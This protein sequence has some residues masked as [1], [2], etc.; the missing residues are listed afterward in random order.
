VEAWGISH[1]A[2]NAGTN[3]SHLS[4]CLSVLTRC[5]RKISR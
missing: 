3:G 1:V 5:P 2:Q 4:G